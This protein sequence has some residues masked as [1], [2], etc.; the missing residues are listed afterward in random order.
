MTKAEAIL[1][2]ALRDGSSSNF[3]KLRRVAFKMLMEA[4]ESSSEDLNRSWAVLR[5]M[6]D[7][8]HLPL[9]NASGRM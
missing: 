1:S 6:L 7:T 5:R 9:V 3:P 8:A 4:S 2:V